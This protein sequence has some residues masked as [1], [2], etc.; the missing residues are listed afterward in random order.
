MERKFLMAQYPRIASLKTP[1]VF[2]ARLDELKIEIPFDNQ[3]ETGAKAPLAQPLEIHG[4][5]IGN[6]C[7]VLPMEG[8]D[9]EL[10]G[11]P[12][13]LTFRRWQNFGRS[14]AKFIWGGEAAAVRHDGRSNTCQLMISEKTIGN[15]AKLREAL[16][17]SHIESMGSD[18]GLYIGL[19][20]THS[21]RFS[22]PNDDH[23]MESRVAYRHPLLEKR[24]AFNDKCHVMTDTD[25]RELIQDY[26]KA[27]ALA[28]KAGFDFVDVKHCH[29]YLAHELLSAVD[30]KGDFGGNFENRIRFFREIVEGINAEVPGMEIGVRLSIYDYIPF[31]KDA[32]GKGTP[33]KWEGR[34][35]YAFGGDGTGIGYDLTEPLKFIDL[36]ASY[37]INLLCATISSPYYV[38]HLQRPAMFPPSDGYQL[39]E[40]PLIEVAK[41]IEIVRKVKELRP[42]MV[43][44][45]SGLT[46]LQEWFPQVVQAAVRKNYMDF[47]GMG[48]M[49]LAYPEMYRDILLGNEL[50]KKK[51]CRTFSE[52][53]T[54]PRKGLVS[55]CYPLDAFYKG[56]PDWARLKEMKK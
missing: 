15:I 14:G 4:K 17:K 42:Q 53:T 19:Q 6:R 24:Y 18:K 44:A 43:I 32:E 30:R 51:I 46:Y 54:A 8:W 28:K 29:G 21:G 23:L 45:G 38:P 2:Q 20:L 48:R 47:A 55:G 5:V 1:E 35:P 50:Q 34:Y 25:L 10:D 39:L 9:C 41:H 3:M 11:N 22:K 27:V 56:L 40:D 7:C 33:E 13:E 52:C 49:V 31:T 12:S 36:M 37:G 16:V 26:I